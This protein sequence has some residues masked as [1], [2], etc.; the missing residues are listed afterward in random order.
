MAPGISCP[1]AEAGRGL[2]PS[3][4]FIC[5]RTLPSCSAKTADI[6]LNMRDKASFVLLGGFDSACLVV[7]IVLYHPRLGSPPLAPK[8]GQ[9]LP[10]TSSRSVEQAPA[11]DGHHIYTC[12]LRT[13]RRA[14]ASAS[15]CC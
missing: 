4:L 9:L 1:Q 3:N 5:W 14:R 11:K 10:N 2:V 12:T 13:S 15:I 7:P 6:G 8:A